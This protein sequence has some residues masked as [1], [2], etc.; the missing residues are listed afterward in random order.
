LL[1]EETYTTE[2][3]SLAAKVKDYVI[4]TKFRLSALV[5]VSALAGYLV[6]APAVDGLSLLYLLVGGFLVTGSSNAFNQVIEREFDKNMERTK[7]RPIAAGRMSVTE[8]LI[9]SFLMGIAG[10][11]LLYMLNPLS[12]VLGFLALFMYV[13]LYTP[14][15]RVTPWAVFVGA[16][17]G[18]IPPMLGYIA[19]TGTFDLTAGMLFFVQFMWQFPH[20]WAIAWKIDD[21]YKKAG[22]SLLPTGKRDKGSAFQI[23]FYSL[24]LIPVSLFPWVF[25]LAGL[26]AASISLVAGTLFY[27]AAV[28]FYRSMEMKHATFLMF[29]SF[30]Y[31]PIVQYAYVIDV[32]LFLP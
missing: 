25:G 7:N 22:F 18:A 28:R 1:A 19:F 11:F 31:L 14:L 16:F 26:F 27:L 32:K 8:G 24:I 5:V 2:K 29:A 9:A 21:D 30:F 12:A 17:P 10:I 13:V 3:F 20:F 15:K 23:M 6:A 4:L